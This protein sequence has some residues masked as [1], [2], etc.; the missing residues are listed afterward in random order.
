MY[1]MCQHA[2]QTG[3]LSGECNMKNVRWK[4]IADVE[5]RVVL[6]VALLD[7]ILE[8]WSEGPWTERM[9]IALKMDCNSL[10]ISFWE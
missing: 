4:S 3:P 10:L 1:A 6:D 7:P 5:C 9:C 8:S 2:H